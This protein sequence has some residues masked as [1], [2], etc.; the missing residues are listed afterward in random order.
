MD[1]HTQ[2]IG[3]CVTVTAPQFLISSFVCMLWNVVCD[4][5]AFQIFIFFWGYF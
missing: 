2:K 4:W 1:L 5:N 3:Y